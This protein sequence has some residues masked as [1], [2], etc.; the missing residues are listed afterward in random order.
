MLSKE[1][2]I[3]V[4]R[5]KKCSLSITAVWLFGSRANNSADST[6][7]WDFFVFSEDYISDQTLLTLKFYREDADLLLVDAKSGEISRLCRESEEGTLFFQESGSLSSW[8]WRKNLD[9]SASYK[10]TK[11]YGDEVT[12]SGARCSEGVIKVKEQR[13][14]QV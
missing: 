11:W 3:H 2:Q 6:S 1:M 4:E 5:L 13:A 12:V 9:G 7:D 10:S 14:F 8:N